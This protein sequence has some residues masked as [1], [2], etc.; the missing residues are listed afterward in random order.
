MPCRAATEPVVVVTEPDRV[1]R[2]E[3]PVE[4]GFPFPPGYARDAGQL[5]LAEQGKILPTQARVMSRWPDGSLR[6]AFLDTRLSLEPGD[7]RVLRLERRTQPQ[8]SGIR[9]DER[10]DHLIVDTGTL[11]FTIPARGSSWITDLRV[12]KRVRLR[13]LSGELASGGK[14]YPA[15]SH[16]TVKILERGAQRVRIEVRGEYGAGFVYVLRIDAFA[17]QP[18]LRLFHSFEMHRAE[19]FAELDGLSIALHAPAKQFTSYAVGRTGKA[20]LSGRLGTRGVEAYQEDARTLHVGS[21]AEESR[22]SGEFELR[23][24]KETISLRAWDFW[25]QYPQAVDFHPGGLT[26]SLWPVKSRPVRIGMGAAKTHEFLVGFTD[27]PARGGTPVAPLRG[28]LLAQVDRQWLADSG[29]MRNALAPSKENDEFLRRLQEGYRRYQQHADREAWDDRGEPFCP[30]RSAE[31]GADPRERR[32]E[33]FYGMLNWGDWNFVGYHDGTKGCDSWGNLEYD[34]PQ[35]LALAYLATG[36]PELGD[37]MVAA[38]RHF[39][40][41]DGIHFN[42]REPA[43][44]GMNHPKA[45]LHFSFALGGVDLGHTWT[46]GLL[47]YAVLTGDERATAAARGIA[48]YL[49]FRIRGKLSRGNPRQWGWPQIALVAMFEA[50]GE[51]KYRAAALEYAR[52]GMAQHPPDRL[53]NWKAGILAE[54][55]AYTHSVTRD[56]AVESWLRRYAAAVVA[57]PGNRDARFLPAVAYV[58]RLTARPDFVA[59]ATAVVPRLDFGNWGKPFSIAGRI[60]FSLLSGIPPVPAGSR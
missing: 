59:L 24:P 3:W 8:G 32:R 31:S 6:W 2:S 45:P 46:E 52:R 49:I 12:G 53:D 44:V 28:P 39:M 50:T 55:L 5:V 21:Q 17:R 15:Q 35:V 18:F 48:D 29:A 26:Y 41:V 36:D 20:S 27:V 40:D 56:A 13:A 19:V 23:A 30:E 43:W 9:I 14:K 33:G 7:R 51:E 42:A 37:G 47:S 25:Q 58:G 57:L 10:P 16:R 54:G 34:M 1:A 4:V 38:A 60:G 22:A 11:Q